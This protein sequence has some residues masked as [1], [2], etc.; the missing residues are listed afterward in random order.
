MSNIKVTVEDGNNVNV[1]VSPRGSQVVRID[2]GVSGGGGT[3]VTSVTGTA[4]ISSSGGTTPDIS[5]SPATSSTDGYLSAANWTTFNSKIGAITSSDNSITVTGGT[6][7]DLVVNHSQN[8]YTYVRNATG[9]TLTKGT[10]VYITGATGQAPTVSKALASSDATS[11]QT[12]GI[13]AADLANNSNGYV[14]IIGYVADIDTSA[15]SDGQQLYLSGTTAGTMT[16]TKPKAPTHLVYV[17]VVEY[18]HPIHG[19]LFV[20]VQNGYELDE[21]HDVLITSP[22]NGQTIIYDSATSLWKN[23][24]VNLSSN[25][26]GNLPVTNL[27]SGTGASGTTFWRGDGTWATPTGGGS[28]TVTQVNTTGSVSGITLTG[29]PITT[30][31]TVTLGGSLNL[32]SPPA[33]GGT[34]PNTITGT[35]LRSTNYIELPFKTSGN[36]GIGYLQ[37]IDGGDGYDY[38]NI[39][40]DDGSGTTPMLVKFPSG[41]EITGSLNISGV[42]TGQS[43]S[44]LGNPA[45]SQSG[46]I[47]LRTYSTG[48]DV[49]IQAPTSLTASPYTLILPTSAGSNNQVLKTDGS[50]N[51]SWLDFD[52]PPAIG[53][54]MPNT[55]KFTTVQSTVATGTAPFTV[56]STTNVANLNASSLNGA[57]F[58]APGSIG[59]TTAGSGAF[60]TITA[61]SNATLAAIS[62]PS[63]PSNGNVTFYAKT[64]AGYPTL[65]ARNALNTSFGLQSAL[66]SKNVQWWVTSAATAG[67]WLGASGAGNGTYANANP[68]LGGTKYQTIRRSTYASS[69]TINLVQGV[70][71]GQASF[72]RGNVAGQGGFFFYTRCGFDTWTNGGRFFAGLSISAVGGTDPSTVN[73]TVGFCVDAA[74]NGAISFLTRG[75]ASTKA[76]TGYT[77]ATNNGYDCYI[78]CAPNSSQYTWQIIDINAGTSASGTATLNLPTNTQIMFPQ[79]ISSNAALTTVAAIK[80]GVASIY[81]ESDY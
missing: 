1:T 72:F 45:F 49:G 26:T 53:S 3:G 74:D 69:A 57:T 63:A 10:V 2:R 64:T 80:I 16:A 38:L 15:Y 13:M 77:I 9:A 75:A 43:A 46:Y 71:N 11:A 20:K 54:T 30:T 36:A 51:L 79:V 52:S 61:S 25:V 31:G 6:T 14:T 73:Q 65:A 81:I 7:A 66:W 24:L 56:A 8:V 22:A 41:A 44:F 50:G 55:G 47:S 17:A 62:D 59:S 35:V 37:M 5:I 28:G 78:Y 42:Y 33:I 21:I 39:Y 12:L 76:S 29:G 18:A 27:N 67:T 60:T 58:A 23:A 4:P 48:Q 68:T 34:T 70:V 40:G 32:S 19:K